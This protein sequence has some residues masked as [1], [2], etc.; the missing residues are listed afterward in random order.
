MTHTNTFGFLPDLRRQANNLVKTLDQNGDQWRNTR[1]GATESS[2]AAM[3]ICL[4]SYKT[5]FELSMEM[6]D[7]NSEP[8]RVGSSDDSSPLWGC[9]VLNPILPDDLEM[10]GSFS[11]LVANWQRLAEPEMLE[12]Q[13]EQHVEH[14]SNE[15]TPARFQSSEVLCKRAKY[16]SEI[17]TDILRKDHPALGAPGTTARSG[18]RDF[19]ISPSGAV[20]EVDSK[21][22]N[23]MEP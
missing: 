23:R 5:P 11:D 14:R 20:G 1:K 4:K 19:T 21:S 12:A 16:P 18:S 3:E 7:D 8:P 10:S 15:A 22:C 9:T 13:R 2:D 17:N 6:K